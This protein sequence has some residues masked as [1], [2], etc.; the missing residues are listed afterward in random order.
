MALL[1]DERFDKAIE[2]F[3]NFIRAKQH[4]NTIDFYSGF[5]EKNEGYKR[6][7]FEAAHTALQLDTWSETIIGKHIILDRIVDALN[8][9]SKK[10]F[11][12]IID[13]HAITQ[14][15]NKAE[16]NIELSETVL[17]CLMTS[18]DVPSAFEDFCTVFGKWYPT[19]SYL[20][21]IRD[22]TEF[23]PVKN[24]E[25]NHIDR[26]VKLGLSTDCLKKCSWHNYQI[27]LAI[28]KEIQHRLA[29]CFDNPN[30]S[31]LDAHSF[32][33]T[34]YYAPIDLS[35][36]DEPTRLQSD[37]RRKFVSD[38]LS[39]RDYT[40]E[41]LTE[42]TK[43]EKE[44]DSLHVQGA[45][46]QALVKIRVNQGTFRKRLLKRYHS[47]C[48]CGVQNTNMLA[49]SH[50]KPW[51]VSDAQEKLDVNNGLLLCPNHDKLFDHGWISISDNGSVIISQQLSAMDRI[52]LNV[53][54]DMT[55]TLFQE[56]KPYF[57][58]HRENI[59]IDALKA[60]DADK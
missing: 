29:S 35:V 59:F 2:W 11:N 5:M 4:N 21:F 58:F 23:L 46:R 56:N 20:L 27:F 41:S 32:V 7:I 52:L 1:N 17:F 37:S 33:W 38:V 54:P 22:C 8:A 43:I 26:F 47:C 50:I 31:L 48:L 40:K 30:V 55:V 24:A 18:A 53:H 36:P 42:V 3:A 51:S 44:L 49:A 25:Q 10:N 9:K 13:Y 16:E 19:L 28:H 45:D 39:R 12:N 57:A 15:K 60:D 14:L 6:E 34:L